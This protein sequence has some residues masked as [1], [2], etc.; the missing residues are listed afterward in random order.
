MESL[1]L[2][3]G[4]AHPHLLAVDTP[5]NSKGSDKGDK[6]S[7]IHIHF[8]ATQLGALMKEGISRWID[9][10]LRPFNAVVGF[11]DLMKDP[12]ALI[13]K[14]TCKPLLRIWT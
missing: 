5:I 10:Q 14:P 2:G 12:M 13:I 1:L 9:K 3:Q 7:S 11:M 6:W 4:N 8:D